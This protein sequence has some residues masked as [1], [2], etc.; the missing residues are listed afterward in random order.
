[1]DLFVIAVRILHIFAG[2][3]WVG[4]AITFFLFVEPSTRALLPESRQTFMGEV[5]GRRKFPMII[6][7]ATI[8][9]VLAGL[10]LYWRDSGGFQLSWITTPTGLGFSLG[11]LAAL[12]SFALGPLA[13]LPAT[14]QL[15]R[16]GGQIMAERRPPT[17]DEESILH[18]LGHQLLVAG[19]IDLAL[20]TV[21]VICMATARYW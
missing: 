19:R 14:G 7:A 15:G 12:A 16:L 5:M 17:P 2:I 6:F 11:A 3:F 20:L 10:T 21:A 1:M 4:A 13:I 18:R 9:T 8:V